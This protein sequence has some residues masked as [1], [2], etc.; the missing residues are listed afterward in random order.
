MFWNRKELPKSSNDVLP[1]KEKPIELNPGTCECGHTRCVHYEGR[2]RCKAGYPPKTEDNPSDEWRFCACQIF[3]RD[4]D[5]DDDPE[6]ETPTPSE[7]ADLYK[8]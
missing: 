5:E 1:P 6:P 3:I 8:R 2:G 4:D 7:L